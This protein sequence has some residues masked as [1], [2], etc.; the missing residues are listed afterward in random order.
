MQRLISSIVRVYVRY[1]PDWP[2]KTRLLR[3]LAN[4]LVTEVRPG[5]WIHLDP[6]VRIE[7]TLLRERLEFDREEVDLI[8]QLL[9]PGMT[10]VDV[11]A[12]VG[13]MAL[14]AARR[15]GAQGRVLAFEA[16]AASLV[17]FARN[18]ELNHAE[19]VTICAMAVGGQR[20]MIQYYYS[21]ESP[22]QSSVGYRHEGD[23]R[24]PM[25]VPLATLDDCLA[26][27][28]SGRVDFI[29][30]DVEGSEPAV[31]AG[32]RAT[33]GGAQAPLLVI[34]LNPGALRWAGNSPEQLVEAL[35]A[36]G[37]EPCVLEVAKSCAYANVVGLKEGHRER[38]PG[39]SNYSLPPL[40]K[41]DWYRTRVLGQG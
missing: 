4:Q 22:D 25:M 6:S 19:N 9:Q 13:I 36:L 34:E 10:V 28:G 12:F 37:Y 32:A 39:L 33:L 21:P 30:I 11:G 24:F 35:I 31:L 27:L 5:V 7:M 26:D 8:W 38:F 15:V 18:R 1:M 2:G 17:R 20:S 16:G 3:P 23:R 40:L 29:K 41:H 14:V